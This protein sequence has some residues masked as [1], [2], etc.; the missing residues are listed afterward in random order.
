M[1]K[2][3][4]RISRSSLFLDLMASGREFALV[5]DEF[6]TSSNRA[7]HSP[8]SDKNDVSAKGKAVW[9]HAGQVQLNWSICWRRLYSLSSTWPH[10]IWHHSVHWSQLNA[11]WLRAITLLQTEQVGLQMEDGRVSGPGFSSIS[12]HI[13]SFD[14]LKVEEELGY[15]PILV[16]KYPFARA[17]NPRWRT[18]VENSCT[19]TEKLWVSSKWLSISV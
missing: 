5:F 11:R 16:A 9:K 4:I 3:I 12:P 19:S 13:I 6:D 15:L 7:Q 14:M 2:C 1:F 18:R 8:S 17:W 10:F